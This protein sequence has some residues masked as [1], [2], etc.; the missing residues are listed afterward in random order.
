MGAGSSSSACSSPEVSPRRSASGAVL[1][2]GFRAFADNYRDQPALQAD[3]RR[4][5]LESS[6]LIIGIDFTKSNEWTGAK[7]FQGRSLH[8][9]APGQRNPYEAAIAVMGETLSTFDE[10]GLIPAY[11]FGCTRTHDNSVFSLRP[12]NAATGADQPCVGFEE[13]LRA[14]GE[15][16][17]PATQLAGP[18]SFGPIIRKACQI[19][20]ASGGQ[21]HI[22]LIVA[23]GQV[24]RPEGMPASEV[25]VQE[26]DTINAIVAACALPL[27]IV[28]IGVGDGPWEQ[29]KEFDDR[30]PERA[31]DNYQFV[32]FDATLAIARASVPAG[33]TPAATKAAIDATFALHALMEVP[34]QLRAIAQ[35][36]LMSAE[37][38]AAVR[39]PNVPTLEPPAPPAAA[40]GA[41]AAMG[42]APS[43]GGSGAR[44]AAPPAANAPAPVADAARPAAAAGPAPAAAAAAAAPA[45]AAAA[46]ALAR[47]HER[48]I[49]ELRE[50]SLCTICITNPRNTAFQ[51]G[52]QVVSPL[53]ALAG[54]ASHSCCLHSRALTRGFVAQRASETPQCS[55]CAP[56]ITVCHLCRAPITQRI[57]LF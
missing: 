41:A 38:S 55:A 44:G 21:Y 40:R 5:G 56:G 48:E 45:A 18:T 52:H 11:G 37:R 23:D 22:L 54:R 42:D 46:A 34:D 17:P 50:A 33:A 35:L 53:S 43:C 57:R 25:S 7:S 51:C 4:A 16:A 14:Y 2:A 30:L 10:D 8:A 13:V 36:G 1:P 49:E 32:P 27:S 26:R 29:M 9:R 24:T 31:F 47:Q 3:L 39:V 28:T 6:N 20:R 15:A 12:R 19:V